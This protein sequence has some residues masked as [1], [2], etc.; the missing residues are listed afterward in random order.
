MRAILN[1]ELLS[2]ARASQGVALRSILFI[3]LTVF[4][5]LVPTLDAQAQS[6][7]RSFQ[8]SL[9]EGG[10]GPWSAG[11]GDTDIHSFLPRTVQSSAQLP[12]RFIVVGWDP[13]VP[14]TDAGIDWSR[15][16]A[17][18]IDEP[19]AS[20]DHFLKFPDNSPAC[21]PDPVALASAIAPIDTMV[22][23]RATE[24]QALAPKARF[25]VNFDRVEAHWMA[26]CS[27]PNVFNRHYIDVVSADWSDDNANNTI[28]TVRPFY[29]V[30]AANRPKPDQQL[31]LIPGTFYRAGIDSPAT[32]ASYLQGYFDY[33]NSA[34]Q[35]C[36]LS[37]GGRG[38][39]GNFDGCPVWMV[40]G[41]LSNT[42]KKD[43]TTY[44]GVLDPGA[45]VIAADWRSQVGMA[46]RP[47][48][49][50]QLKPGEISRL[51]FHLLSDD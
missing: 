24:L 17:V 38:V 9:W 51:V 14:L 29:S 23:Q 31:A 19:Y 1:G 47:D 35:N 7:T 41:W 18:E 32:Q 40:M 28:S 42:F 10:G 15:V 8:I 12:G 20:V 21:Q 34:N 43:G 48:L 46:V 39:T 25:W 30:V 16:V 6:V 4:G 49:A 44:V 50:H 37:P 33:A 11:N 2:R 45:A 36:N 3:V 22:Q 27:R 26:Y 5:V 13:T